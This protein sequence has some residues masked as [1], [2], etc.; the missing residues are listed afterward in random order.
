MGGRKKT[1]PD[2]K[3]LEYIHGHEDVVLS[4]SEMADHFDFSKSGMRDRLVELESGGHLGHKVA[5]GTSI[6]W[7][8]DAGKHFVETDE[9]E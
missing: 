7:L 4:T 9:N 6:W 8:T 1:V 5:G 3:L 2:R